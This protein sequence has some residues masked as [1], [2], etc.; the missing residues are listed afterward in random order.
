MGLSG[1]LLAACPS[2]EEVLQKAEESGKFLAEKQAQMVKGVGE[3]LKGKGKEGAE[4]LSEGVGEV[5]KG[6]A[7]GLDKSLG[8]VKVTTADAVAAR[9]LKVERGQRRAVG[10][11][12][13]ISLY[14]ISDQAFDGKLMLRVVDAAGKEVGRSTVELKRAAGDAG[15]VDFVFDERT[16]LLTLDHVDLGVL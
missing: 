11:K 9:G 1:V 7:Q 6:T 4:S 2:K 13:G 8:E 12:D 5:L 14:L 3:G 16:P 10:G 15:Y